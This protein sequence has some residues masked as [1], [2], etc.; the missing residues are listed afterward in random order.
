MQKP[1][2]KIDSETGF[3]PELDMYFNNNKYGLIVSSNTGNKATYLPKVFENISWSDIKD[4][5]FSKA[6]IHN[7]NLPN[8]V[9]Y[10][11][12]TKNIK[13]S[14]YKILF[15]YQKQLFKKFGNMV[16]PYYGNGNIPFMITNQGQ[17]I[18]N[19]AEVIRNTSVIGTYLERGLF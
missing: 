16:E 14:I 17:I 1:L 4:S 3:I 11:Y 5:I 2:Y 13:R 10:A 9:F 18:M 19:N 6:G 12:K 7:N 15:T 8:V